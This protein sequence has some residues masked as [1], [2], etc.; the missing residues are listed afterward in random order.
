[1]LNLNSA[2]SVAVGDVRIPRDVYTVRCIE[3]KFGVSPQKQTPLITMTWEIV[4]PKSI[5]I[6]GV[7]VT[8]Q[9]MKVQKTFFLTEKAIGRLAEFHRKAGLPVDVS[10][11]T[12]DEM[13]M[14]DFCNQYV[15]LEMKAILYSRES[16]QKKE[17]IL[18]DGTIATENMLD[19]EG[20]P[21]VSYWPEMDAI[22]SKA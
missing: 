2:E 21:I 22:L 15:G 6:K 3:A 11:N 19:D 5:T 9:G 17:V 1:M 7:N 12:E 16:F 10:I 4:A 14:E 18:E 13:A 8:I 20:R